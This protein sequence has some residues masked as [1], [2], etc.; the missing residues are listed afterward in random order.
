MNTIMKG[1]PI[2]KVYFI[3]NTS[4][5]DPEVQD[6]SAHRNKYKIQR[7]PVCNS[8]KPVFKP[9]INSSAGMTCEHIHLTTDSYYSSP[10]KTYCLSRKLS[11][12]Y[13]NRAESSDLDNHA[14]RG[15]LCDPE[16]RRELFE[17]ICTEVYA[18]SVL[19]EAFSLLLKETSYTLEHQQGECSVTDLSEIYKRID[20]VQVFSQ[21]MDE[22]QSHLLEVLQKAE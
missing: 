9:R 17:D 2:C 1:K 13:R 3:G 16:K 10:V 18:V 7:I 8:G 4:I 5:R 22:I 15:A 12:P 19:N 11:S 20:R 21:M 6:I 14:L